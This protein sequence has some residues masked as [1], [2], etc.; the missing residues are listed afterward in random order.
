MG[1]A[2]LSQAA[3]AGSPAV[4][5]PLLHNVCRCFGDMRRLCKYTSQA[6]P[7]ASDSGQGPWLQQLLLKV[8]GFPVFLCLLT[9]LLD[10]VNTDARAPTLL[11]GCT[12]P[13]P[14]GSS[15][16]TLP[17]SFKRCVYLLVPHFFWWTSSHHGPTWYSR[18][19]LY[20]THA[21]LLSAT[22][23]DTLVP[24]GG[25]GSL[26]T[27]QCEVCPLPWG[28]HSPRSAKAQGGRRKHMQA[29]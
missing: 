1:D 5:W 8:T 21:S 24:F 27:D 19:I 2:G 7:N 29:P 22:A 17:G 15:V 3:W 14:D 28:C 11:L 26:E 13:C 4:K 12:Q 9:G 10:G 20:I 16:P 25:E 18:P 23:Q 6:L